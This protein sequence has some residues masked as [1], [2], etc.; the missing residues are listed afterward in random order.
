[1]LTIALNRAIALVPGLTKALN[2]VE[3]VGPFS[4]FSDFFFVTAG[5]SSLITGSLL[6]ALGSVFGVF[7]SWKKTRA[8]TSAGVTVPYRRTSPLR[9]LVRT[10]SRTRTD[11]CS[12]TIRLRRGTALS[13]LTRNLVFVRR[14]AT[15]KEK[16]PVALVRIGLP[17]S[18]Y[19]V[20]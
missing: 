2:F 12:G 5:F 16:W 10:F 1:M 17:T 11:T 19:A 7:S 20:V 9:L 6:G 18:T 15:R 8:P 13:V 4:D 14:S 3:K